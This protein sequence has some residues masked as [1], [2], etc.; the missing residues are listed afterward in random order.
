MLPHTF[1]RTLTVYNQTGPYNGRNNI[2]HEWTSKRICKLRLF[3]RK[4]KWRRRRRRKPATCTGCEYENEYIVY[5]LQSY[6]SIQL[7]WTFAWMKMY[8]DNKTHGT[9]RK[10]ALPA[11]SWFRNKVALWNVTQVPLQTNMS[12]QTRSQIFML[13]WLSR[14]R[15]HNI[16][17]LILWTIAICSHDTLAIVMRVLKSL[18]VGRSNHLLWN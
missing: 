11:P 17:Y 7:W 1:H 3:K 15:E 8:D 9:F 6:T 16:T 2:S 12:T 10:R 4:R 18:T 14:L 13:H 5:E